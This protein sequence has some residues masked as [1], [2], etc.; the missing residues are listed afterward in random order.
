MI[1][2]LRE[3]ESW[4]WLIAPQRARQLGQGLLAASCAA[5]GVVELSTLQLLPELHPYGDIPRPVIVLGGA[6]QLLGALLLTVPNLMRYAAAA[7]AL[8]WFAALVATAT[9]AAG[10]ASALPTW[11]PV[12]ESAALFAAFLDL[13]RSH[14]AA[15]RSGIA[16]RLAFGTMLLLF[17]L[18]HIIYRPAIAGMIPAWI[19]LEAWWPLMTGGLML[20]AGLAILAGRL[21]DIAGV[22]VAALFASWLVVVHPI[23]I[24]GDPGSI[25]EWEFALTALALTGAA[26]MVAGNSRAN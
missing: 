19:P 15:A 8:L 17:G 14:T 3:H 22:M 11:V 10:G 23:R 25:A 24:W 4:P 9:A 20:L 1:A 2:M 16:L 26:M 12:L 21:A 7:L 5:M 13:A 18:I 6:A